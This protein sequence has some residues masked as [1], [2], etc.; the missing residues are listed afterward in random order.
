MG[1]NIY[2]MSSRFRIRKE[3]Q[4]DALAAVKALRGQE[5]QK[6]FTNTPGGHFSFINMTEFIQAETLVDAMCA[7]RWIL[8]DDD[9]GDLYAPSFTGEYLGDEDILFSA[10]APFVES[11]SYI[12]VFCHDDECVWRW[13]FENGS[14]RREYAHIEF[15]YSGANSSASN[16]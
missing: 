8:E 10:I 12:Q 4:A 7:W 13:V 14:V 3:R 15:S 5:T 1:I 9:N 2:S 16:A 6:R 11:G